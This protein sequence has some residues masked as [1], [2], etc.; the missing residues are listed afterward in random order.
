[1]H[2]EIGHGFNNSGVLLNLAELDYA[3]GDYKQSEAALTKAVSIFR[4]LGG[5]VSI[6]NVQ[7]RL[8]YIAARQAKYEQSLRT[9]QACLSVYREANDRSNMTACVIGLA[10]LATMQ[11]QAR[12]AATFLSTASALLGV[13]SANLSLIERLEREAALDSARAQLSEAEFNTAW[14][15]GRALSLEQAIALAL[16]DSGREEVSAQS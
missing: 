15:E 4:E 1:M 16:E 10:R 8:A 3:Q 12:K 13:G 9:F 7:R 5:R 2:E 11:G 6:A 14:E